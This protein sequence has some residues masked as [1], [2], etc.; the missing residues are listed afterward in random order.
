MSTVD[1]QL[2]DE[3]KKDDS[4][5]K[6]D[7]IKKYHQSG[8]N[9]GNENSNTNFYFGE[10]HYCLQVDNGYLEIDIK[11][12]KADIAN[13]ANADVIRIII[14]AFASTIQIARIPT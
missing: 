7:F 1:F 2:L 13:F 14:N 9:V 6:Q 11:I 4:F 12:R 5:I 10:T 3:E 8:P